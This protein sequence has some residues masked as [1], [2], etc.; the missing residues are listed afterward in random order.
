MPES[1]SASISLKAVRDDEYYEE[2][3]TSYSLNEGETQ[4]YM[5]SP[6]GAC[7]VNLT[8]GSIVDKKHCEY[9]CGGYMAL[10]WTAR[11]GLHRRCE[12]CNRT[13]EV[14]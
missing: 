1:A 11:R 3:V 9:H 2:V 14:K 8:T 6:L 12:K 4:Y 5:K 7:T 13:K 10:N